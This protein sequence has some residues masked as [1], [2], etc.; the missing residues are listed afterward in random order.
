MTIFYILNVMLDTGLHTFV[1][2]DRITELKWVFLYVNYTWI[3]L[4]Q[5]KNP[6]NLKE[7]VPIWEKILTTVSYFFSLHYSKKKWANADAHESLVRKC[8]DTFQ[9]Y[10]QPWF[11]ENRNQHLFPLSLCHFHLW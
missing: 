3:N 8:T 11:K 5:T 2:T 1:K 4:T 10:L 9:K 7:Y 6:K